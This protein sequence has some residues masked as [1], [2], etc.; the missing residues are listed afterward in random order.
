MCGDECRV[1]VVLSNPLAVPLRLDDVYLH[2]TFQPPTAT[3]ATGPNPPAASPSGSPGTTGGAPPAPQNPP[4][5][6]APSPARGVQAPSAAASAPAPFWQPYPLQLVLPPGNKAVR[7]V[8]GGRALQP[9]TLTL[10][11][12]KVACGGASWVQ[13]WAVPARKSGAT[14]S[15]APAA[16]GSG[17]A[18]RSSASGSGAS[19]A[20]GGAAVAAGGGRRG[21]DALCALPPSTVE[22]AVTVLPPLPLLQAT[23]RAP[24]AQ[25]GRVG[26]SAVLQGCSCCCD[27][28]P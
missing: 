12:V 2:A 24:D 7:V 4:V 8:L 23:L 19:S 20:A 11:G 10:L 18:S 17:G 13:P 15:A 27:G 3:S 5:T 6:P 22:V 21:R 16:A 1:E 14:T 26:A 25:V 28:M 9:G